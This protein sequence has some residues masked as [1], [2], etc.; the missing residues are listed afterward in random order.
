MAIKGKGKTKSRPAAR[1]P[2]PVPVVR[3]P[4]FFARR[5]VQLVG[6][7]LLGVIAVMVVV[8]AT[9]GLRS[10]DAA[11]ARATDQAN[12]RRVIQEW[13]TT[14]DGALSKLGSSGGGVGPIVVLPTLSASVDTLAKGDPDQQAQETADEAVGLVDEAVKTLEGVDLPTLITDNEGL[15]VATTNDVLN[16]K[17]RMVDGLRLYG[18]VAAMVRAATAED[19]D[20]A[21]A[22]ALIREAKE[23]LPLAKQVF[24]EGYADYTSALGS[25]GLSQPTPGLPGIGGQT[26]IPST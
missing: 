1:A 3:K 4:P 2:R 24:D 23:L 17:A 13:Q 10:N 6:A 25:A 5:W 8:W 11:D 7:V 26:A 9:N 16:S 22:D 15:D 14:V 18:R 21:V 20:P 19:V 12:A